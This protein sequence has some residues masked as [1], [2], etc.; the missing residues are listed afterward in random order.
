[1]GVYERYLLPHLTNLAMR[2]QVL[3]RERRRY[4]PLATGT[5]LEIG[6]GSARNLPY[7]GAAV[8]RLVALEPSHE[9]WR[10]GRARV[11]E[12]R[13]PVEHLPCPAEAIAARDQTFDTVVMTW[14]LCTIPDPEAAL[15][16][17]AR[18]LKPGG[19]LIFVEHGKAPDAG[20]AAWQNRLNPLWRPIAGGCNMNR[21]IATLIAQRFAVAELETGYAA[22]PKVLS[23]L[24]KGIATPRR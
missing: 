14:T 24:Y 1:M 12:A 9:L 6:A 17:M 19:R 23:Y 20:V 13:F 11:G 8:E 21:A 5:V 10:L 7:Y 2:N 18:V 15:A 3:A 22:G 4:V 16:E